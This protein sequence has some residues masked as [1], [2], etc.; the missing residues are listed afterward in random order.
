MMSRTKH[1]LSK[2]RIVIWIMSQSQ[3]QNH[4]KMRLYNL[5]TMNFKYSSMYKIW[6]VSK[7]TILTRG[8]LLVKRICITFPRHKNWRIDF[9][10]IGSSLPQCILYLCNWALS[11]WRRVK[12]A[13]EI[14]WISLPKTFS[15]FAF[16]PLRFTF[17]AMHFWLMLEVA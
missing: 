13:R 14:R 11:Y 7:P 9:L 3:S 4:N 6:S 17:V 15:I 12:S 2:N 8:I 10:N 16:R 5:R 1:Q